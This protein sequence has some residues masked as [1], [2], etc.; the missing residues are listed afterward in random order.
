MQPTTRLSRPALLIWFAAIV[1]I[2]MVTGRSEFVNKPLLEGFGWLAGFYGLAILAYV[3]MV[4]AGE[5]QR[6]FRLAL[7]VGILVRVVLVFCYPNLSD[8]YYRYMWDG[9]LWVEGVNPMDMLPS[10]W[11]ARLSPER[12]Q[13]WQFLYLYD[14]LNS[15]GYYTVYPPVL[16]GVFAFTASLARGNEYLHVVLMKAVIFLA[17]VGTI[18]LLVRIVRR[19]NLSRKAVLLYALNPMVVVELSG[20]C[21]WEALMIFFF[22]WA[23]WLLM[24]YGLV[25]SAPVLAGA[26]G[27]K[28]LP[29]LVFPFLVRRLGWVRTLIFG[30][31][32]AACCL[33]LF[34]YMLEGDRAGHFMDSLRLY[35]QSFEFNG[36]LYDALRG[37]LGDHG[38]WVNAILPWVMLVL[39]LFS[40]WRERNRV[41]SGLPMAMLVGLTLYQLHSPVVHP[42]Y[43]T[44][45]VALAALG[46]YRFPVVWSFILPFTYMA[47]YMPGGIHVPGWL[48]V[49]E[50]GVLFAFIGYE[51]VFKR[52]RLTLTEWLVRRPFLRRLAQRS[53]PARMRIK[54]GRI[55]RHLR[56]GERVLD[57]GTG[58]GGLCLAL[59]HEGFDVTAV[60]VVDMSFFPEVKPVLYDG[61]VLPFE[62]GGF[63]VGLLITV[64]HHVGEPE[65]VIREAMRVTGGRLVIMEDI[66]GNVFQKYLTFFTDSLVN[67]EF[68]GHPHANKSD[69]EWR[70]VFQR[71]GLRV[72]FREDFRTLGVFR[73]VVYVVEV[74][75]GNDTP[76]VNG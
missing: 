33:P 63:D 67:L 50:Y 16:Q 17:E 38:Y 21:H 46:P 51:W 15:K 11:H 37:P 24:I 72:V 75:T 68:E 55:S 7:G 9:Q 61:K 36:G 32:T 8:D 25:P 14:H 53:I 19:F 45:L 29:L 60:D 5:D 31:L 71:L 70:E 2:V 52:Q 58:N 48:L 66:Y 20:N 62:D 3:L 54:Q 64:L 27:T 30:L 40:A 12:M 28:L 44:P 22:L 73:Q 18:L 76:G 13:D 26:I 23:F 39:V 4:R 57:I 34:F 1:A 69:R 10:E 74:A 41:W 56:E 43:I 42:W 6:F 49:L 47:Y 65:Q 59:R 35:F